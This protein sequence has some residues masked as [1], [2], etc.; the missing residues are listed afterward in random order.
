MKKQVI[1]SILEIILYIMIGTGTNIST[2]LIL[3]VCTTIDI[4]EVMVWT[5]MS[6][7][8]ALMIAG[9]IMESLLGGREEDE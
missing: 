1:H 6:T 9:L 8:A 7:L 5:F 2:A 3:L 4:I